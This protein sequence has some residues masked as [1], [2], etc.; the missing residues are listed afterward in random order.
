M[1]N[2]TGYTLIEVVSVIVL[3]GILSVFGARFIAIAANAAITHDRTTGRIV[4]A[5][6]GD[7]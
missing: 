2:E 7:A 5:G 4:T 6:I 1:T 3:L